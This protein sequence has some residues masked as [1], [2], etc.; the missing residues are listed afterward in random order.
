MKSQYAVVLEEGENGWIIASVPS[1]PGCHTQGRTREEALKNAHE[2]IKGYLAVLRE[3]GESV[4]KPDI[5]IVM[6][7]VAA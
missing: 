1:L 5:D 3:D 7:R 2:A 4:P 6:V